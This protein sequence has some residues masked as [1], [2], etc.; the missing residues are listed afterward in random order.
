[1]GMQ[2]AGSR[3]GLSRAGAGT[4]CQDAPKEGAWMSAPALRC[5]HLSSC[6]CGSQLSP[7]MGASHESLMAPF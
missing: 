4:T 7:H 6:L 3:E 1:M 2:V 5:E